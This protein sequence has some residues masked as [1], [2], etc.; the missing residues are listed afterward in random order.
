V[1]L[2]LAVCALAVCAAPLA[3]A[4]ES[5]N[6]YEAGLQSIGIPAGSPAAAGVY[7]RQM[8][9]RLPP[10]GFDPLVAAVDQ[11]NP[12]LTMHQSALVIGSAVANFCL[13][14]SYLL[15]HDLNY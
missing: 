7:G 1:K 11:E 4:D 8:C 3:R 9:D 15:P 2:I 13:D 5:D 12:G 14:K 6:A 10:T